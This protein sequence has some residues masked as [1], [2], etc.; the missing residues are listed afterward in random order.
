M[1]MY[2]AIV[3]LF[4]MYIFAQCMYGHTHSACKHHNMHTC[5]RWKLKMKIKSRINFLFIKTSS[6]HSMFESPRPHGQGNMDKP[7]H[8]KKGWTT[9][10]TINMFHD[11]NI[12]TNMKKSK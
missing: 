7:Y 12:M 5:L 10:C 4:K 8:S 11:I 2:A 1:F 9:F 3:I 6:I